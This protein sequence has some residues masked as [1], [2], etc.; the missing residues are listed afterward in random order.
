MGARA[1]WAA[2]LFAVVLAV[3]AAGCRFESLIGQ[4]RQA[5]KFDGIFYVATERRL[6]LLELKTCSERVQLT[7]MKAARIGHPIDMSPPPDGLVISVASNSRTVPVPQSRRTAACN[8]TVTS[9]WSLTSCLLSSVS[10]ISRV[11]R[12]V[13]ERR[14]TSTV[15]LNSVPRLDHALPVFRRLA[16]IARTLKS[17]S[18]IL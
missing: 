17:E 12:G 13:P 16:D 3:C 10:A 1:A 6:V 4:I 2:I 5:E 11:V 14:I 8:D 7:L 9:G 15:D 18:S